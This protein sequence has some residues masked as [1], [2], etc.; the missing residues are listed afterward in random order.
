MAQQYSYYV[1]LNFCS[2]VIGVNNNDEV[3]SIFIIVVRNSALCCGKRK[4]IVSIMCLS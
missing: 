1:R 2:I 3:N 4:L